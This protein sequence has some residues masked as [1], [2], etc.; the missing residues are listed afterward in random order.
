MKVICK[1]NNGSIFKENEIPP[2][3]SLE[4]EFALEVEKEYIVMGIIL[5]NKFLLFLV[6]EFSNPFWYPSI[7]FTIQDNKISSS[8]YFKYFHQKDNNLAE[9]IWGYYELCLDENHN[10][11]LMDREADDLQIYFRHKRKEF[12]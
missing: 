11:R 4:T 12:E 10:D 1:Y 5:Y 7:L 2:G 6:D 9:A 8:W 3:Y